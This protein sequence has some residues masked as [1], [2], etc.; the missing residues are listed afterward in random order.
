MV[1]EDLEA[2]AV[3]EEVEVEEAVM[4]VG[5]VVTEVEV[6]SSALYMV[7]LSD[8]CDSGKGHLLPYALLL[9]LSC[10]DLSSD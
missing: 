8:V 6:F 3:V 9:D 4:E 1:E 5:E 10:Q 7:A 2:E